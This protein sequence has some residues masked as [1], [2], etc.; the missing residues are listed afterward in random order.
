M[1]FQECIFCIE[2][3]IKCSDE[4]NCYCSIFNSPFTYNFA[5]ALSLSEF[6]QIANEKC[7]C[8]NERGNHLFLLRIIE[9]YIIM[10]SDEVIKIITRKYFQLVAHISTLLSLSRCSILFI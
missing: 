4:N 6:R 2:K 3:I 9:N 10:L 5:F 8:Y 7:A 1:L